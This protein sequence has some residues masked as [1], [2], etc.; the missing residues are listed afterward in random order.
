MKET[1]IPIKLSL[2]SL[3]INVLSLK[4]KKGTLTIYSVLFI[5]WMKILDS[6]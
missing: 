3:L 2:I 6:L 1:L 4:N 5:I